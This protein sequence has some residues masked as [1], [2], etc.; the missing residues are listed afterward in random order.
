MNEE[1][2]KQAGIYYTDYRYSMRDVADNLCISETS[3]RRYL[4][5]YL[6]IIDYEM[7]QTAQR[8]KRENIERSRAHIHRDSNGRFT[9]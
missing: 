1:A 7:W 8:I 2:V 6:K 9:K 5:V 3:A 4:N